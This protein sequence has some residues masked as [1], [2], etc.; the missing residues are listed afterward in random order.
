MFHLAQSKTHLNTTTKIIVI[1]WIRITKMTFV[2]TSKRKL[3]FLRI[4]RIKNESPVSHSYRFLRE[5][6]F[7]SF[8]SDV[9]E[10]VCYFSFLLQKYFLT[11]LLL[12]LS[13]R[14]MA[15][16]CA[17]SPRVTN[18]ST[19]IVTGIAFLFERIWENGCHQFLPFPL[20]LSSKRV[21]TIIFLTQNR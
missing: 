17:I 4:R 21:F 6:P 19:F 8:S 11:S 1:L 9:S 5:Y 3:L 15:I 16:M 13:R 12:F 14:R 20:F 2:P 18:W 10:S 7:Y